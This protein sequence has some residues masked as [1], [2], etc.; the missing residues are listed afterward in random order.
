MK[1]LRNSLATTLKTRESSVIYGI[2]RYAFFKVRSRE[3]LFTFLEEHICSERPKHNTMAKLYL[4]LLSN[5]VKSFLVLYSFVA[6]AFIV[7]LRHALLAHF[8]TYQPLRIQ[9]QRCYL[10]ACSLHFPDLTHRLPTDEVHVTV[11]RYLDKKGWK[12]YVIPGTVSPRHSFAKDRVLDR[13]GAVIIYAH[14][15]GYARGEAKMY[16]NYF[17]RWV[18]VAAERGIDIVFVSVEYRRLAQMSDECLNLLI[19]DDRLEQLSPQRR[20][21]LRNET[22]SLLRINTS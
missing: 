13:P 3:L 17:Q 2:T 11:A 9:L 8:P 16:L 21:I 14:G 5:P 18:K 15:G 20:R 22:P 12:A 6:Q 7:L 4:L 1:V 10:A 19:I